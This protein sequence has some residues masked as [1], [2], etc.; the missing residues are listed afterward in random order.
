[1]RQ[2]LSA[3]GSCALTK[4]QP[5][6]RNLPRRSSLRVRLRPA[7][8]HRDLPRNRPAR[9]RP[10][11]RRQKRQAQ[12]RRAPLGP[13]LMRRPHRRGLVPS[14]RRLRPPARFPP[15]PGRFRGLS[16]RRLP[17]QLHRVQAP[18]RRTS[19]RAACGR[20]RAAHP[21][22][23]R[24]AEAC[25]PRGPVAR[26]RPT[27]RIA[28]AAAGVREDPPARCRSGGGPSPARVSRR[29]RVLPAAPSHPRASSP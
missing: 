25:L 1:M 18:H 2:R 8:R 9:A 19:H 12:R 15:A 21:R 22:R 16:R 13:A 24:A 7:W 4:R 17:P 14:R 28:A 23:L 26:S 11:R 29:P 10:A 3:S 20:F 6:R 27:R 5:A